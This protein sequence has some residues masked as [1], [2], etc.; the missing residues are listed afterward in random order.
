MCFTL[1]ADG[2][3]SD[4][5]KCNPHL[6]DEHD[7]ENGLV[8]ELG[9][10]AGEKKGERVRVRGGHVAQTGA[11]CDNSEEVGESSVRVDLREAWDSLQDDVKLSSLAG[12]NWNTCGLNKKITMVSLLFHKE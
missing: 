9:F 7:G 1:I 12:T 5:A 11:R 10:A 4:R 2:L 8:D 6:I 3:V